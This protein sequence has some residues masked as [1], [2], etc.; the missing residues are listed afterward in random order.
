MDGTVDGKVW[1]GFFWVR[2]GIVMGSF[3]RNEHKM[4][5]IY[6]L[7]TSFLNRTAAWN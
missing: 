7:S 6:H 5:G 3:E 1:I 2:I 4:Q